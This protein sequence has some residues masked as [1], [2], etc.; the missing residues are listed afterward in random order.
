VKKLEQ[1]E[2]HCQFLNDIL[3]VVTEQHSQQSAYGKMA[4]AL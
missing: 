2:M 4:N 1:R 3:S